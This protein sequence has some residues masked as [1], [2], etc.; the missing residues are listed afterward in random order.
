MVMQQLQ[1]EFSWNRALK[2]EGEA[3]R[4]KAAVHQL[5]AASEADDPLNRVTMEEVI[6]TKNLVI[7]SLC[8]GDFW[9]STVVTRV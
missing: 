8:Q 9:S 1:L 4:A 6:R 7:V 3:R 2:P 5:P